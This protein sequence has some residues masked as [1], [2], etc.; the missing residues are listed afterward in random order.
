MVAF[1]LKFRRSV[2]DASSHGYGMKVGVTAD[3]KDDEGDAVATV[4]TY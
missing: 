3:G 1:P 2:A 4:I